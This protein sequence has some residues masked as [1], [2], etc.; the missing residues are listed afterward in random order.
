MNEERKLAHIEQI[1]SLEPIEN[2]DFLEKA[3]VLG[4]H[5]VVKK[6]EFKVGDKVIYIEVDSVLP[7]KEEFEFMT[8][9][10]Y[11]VKTIKLRS[12]YSSGY[13]APLK[14][15][16]EYF[17]EPIVKK[18]YY[19]DTIRDTRLVKKYFIKAD[20]TKPPQSRSDKKSSKL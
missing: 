10:K 20:Y 11:R 4:W 8:K 5:V 2:S 9:Y 6:D 3:T 18:E 1:V 19:F 15:L 16:E 12:V 13:I 7:E 17:G 14:Q